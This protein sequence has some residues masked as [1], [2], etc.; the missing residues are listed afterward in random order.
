MMGAFYGVCIMYLLGVAVQAD[1]L[2]SEWETD[3]EAEQHAGEYKLELMY[4]LAWPF[5]ALLVIASIVIS[6]IVDLFWKDKGEKK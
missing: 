5:I 6:N 4:I 2:V 3:E 1:S